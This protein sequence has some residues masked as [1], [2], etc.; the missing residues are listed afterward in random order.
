MS[1]AQLTTEF[2]AIT[3]I[4]LT[5][6]SIELIKEAPGEVYDA[7][8]QLWQTMMANRPNLPTDFMTEPTLEYKDGHL[9]IGLT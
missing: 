7:A 9:W 3:K 6:L 2:N 4:R 5:P 8:C 1:N